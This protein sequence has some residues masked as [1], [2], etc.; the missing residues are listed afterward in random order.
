MPTSDSLNVGTL[1]AYWHDNHENSGNMLQVDSC[2]GVKGFLVIWDGPE[3]NRNADQWAAQITAKNG[4]RAVSQNF[5]ESHGDPG[6][7]QL[8]GRISLAGPDSISIR[9]RG[10]FGSIWGTWSPTASLYCLEN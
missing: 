10:R 5:R 3:G 7:F 8:D 4:S 6:Y 1:G 2:T 9:V